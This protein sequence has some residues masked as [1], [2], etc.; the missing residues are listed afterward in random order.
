MDFGGYAPVYHL[1][2]Y[3]PLCL[4]LVATGD[5]VGAGHNEPHV[6]GAA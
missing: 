4:T 2:G 3:G 1:L 5:G 6:T